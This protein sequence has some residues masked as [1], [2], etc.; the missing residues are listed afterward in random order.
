M[1]ID[2][3]SDLHV[4]QWM[5]ETI[6][7]DPDRRMWTGEPYKSQF[8]HIDWRYYKNPESRVLIIA[9]DTANS[10]FTSKEVVGA[11]AEEYEHVI[12][13]DG[14]HEHYGED[15]TVRN[16]ME[17]F[18]EELKA[19]PNVH[20]LD[21]TDTFVL[22]GVA[23]FGATGWYDF[24][25]YANQ[26]ITSFTAQRAWASYSNDSRYPDFDGSSPLRMAME[27]S[28]QLAENVR[29][30]QNDD[31]VASIVMTTHMSPRA[32]IMQWKAGDVFWNTL[33][34]SYV[35]TSLKN[36]LEADV[37]KKIR[38]WVYGHTHTRKMTEIDGVIYAN[39]ARGYPRENPPFT[40]TQ[41]EVPSK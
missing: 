12:V 30:V 28:V 21:G 4:D 41:I 5:G 18:K 25:A 33:T 38:Y 40:L 2:F 14:N 3:C 13:V 16:G 9:G 23:F 24:E 7:H 6:L 27:Q 32:D 8:L 26:G 36:C 11:A 1:K 10:L 37:N 22:D 19:F 15:M 39:N 35:N 34:P 29:D 31:E 20:Y 17:F